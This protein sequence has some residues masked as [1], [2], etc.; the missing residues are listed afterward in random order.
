MAGVPSGGGLLEWNLERL[1]SVG[2]RS[3]WM[4]FH[5][6]WNVSGI[7]QGKNNSYYLLFFTD[8]RTPINSRKLLELNRYRRI[9]IWS[10]PPLNIRSTVETL[11]DNFCT[12]VRQN[13]TLLAEGIFIHGW[14]ACIISL[15][16]RRSVAVNGSTFSC[17]SCAT[18]T[19]A[20]S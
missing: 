15:Y 18:H 10:R 9:P 2:R 5:T 19:A 4:E 7:F 13:H 8:S 17:A 14:Y 3:E 11:V 12:V 20:L 16:V 6:P 1:N